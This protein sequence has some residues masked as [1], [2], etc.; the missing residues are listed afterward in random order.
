MKTDVNVKT[1]IG[2]GS[3]ETVQMSFTGPGWVL[4]QPSEGRVL[5]TTQG[6]GGGGILG[7]LT[8]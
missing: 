8:S 2:K 3:G 6:T 5:P 4:V 7:N 1:L